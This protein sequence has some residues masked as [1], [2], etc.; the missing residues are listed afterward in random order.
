[1]MNAAKSTSET[2]APLQSNLLLVG[3]D[4][5]QRYRSLSVLCDSS[6][7]IE[8]RSK[9]FKNEL[10]NRKT[11]LDIQ[12]V[13]YHGPISKIHVRLKTNCGALTPTSTTTNRRDSGWRS[14]FT[15]NDQEETA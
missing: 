14:S 11:F 13:H 2:S 9:S 12:P 3:F 5:Q 1:M 10:L 7:Q 6:D 15:L 8:Q 4:A